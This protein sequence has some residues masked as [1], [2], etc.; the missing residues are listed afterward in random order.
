[1]KPIREKKFIFKYTGVRAPDDS[2]CRCAD[3]F[4][5]DESFDIEVDDEGNELVKV[6]KAVG[7][8]KR[9]RGKYMTPEYQALHNV[10][11]KIKPA[12]QVGIESGVKAF[13]KKINLHDLVSALDQ[14][15]LIK[16]RQVVPWSE[17]DDELKKN[18]ESVI[19]TGIAESA[20]KSKFIFKGAIK[21]LI[22]VDPK[23]R[24]D[25]TNERIK[26][27]A[28][29]YTATLVEGIRKQTQEA[30]SSFAMDAINRGIPP[31]QSADKIK[32]IVGLNSRQSQALI[33]R[34]QQLIKSGFK[35]TK[36]DAALND[37]RDKQL[38]YRA[39]TIARTEASFI[40]NNGLAMIVEENVSSGY[41]D[42]S[43][44]KKKWVVTPHDN[45]CD[46]CL[47]MN[48]QTV[49][50]YDDFELDDGQSISVPPAHPNCLC[51]WSLV[52]D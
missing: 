19:E 27:Y 3:K 35:G 34:E 20:A 47:P 40:N 23:I 48:G 36:L 13:R 39:E 28:E 29:K 32:Q 16:V 38:T 15:D 11:R 43:A 9:T 50:I 24:F 26:K 2:K 52:F 41:I 18:L 51:G 30:I 42:P 46:V 17:L 4:W 21:S 49:G 37:Y 44:A 14:G 5:N 33:N 10:T 31:R 45:I 1:M 7:S 8:N 6:E 12:I 22:G 25:V